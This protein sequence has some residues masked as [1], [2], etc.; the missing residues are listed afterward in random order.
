MSM[1]WEIGMAMGS[2]YDE[3]GYLGIQYDGEGEQ[4]SGVDPFETHAIAGV[5][6]RPMD[7]GVDE[8]G[9]PDP[10]QA[11]QVLVGIEASGKGHI[12]PMEDPRVVALLP[13]AQPGERFFYG[14]TGAF[15]RFHIDGAIS[16]YTTDQG[17]NPAGQ[18]VAM[19]LAPDGW[20]VDAPWGRMTF[21][22]NG[23]YIS[24]AGGPTFDM[25]AMSLPAP[26]DQISSSI[27]MQAKSITL[28]AASV[29]AGPGA[30]TSQPLVGVTALQQVLAA[31]V[32]VIQG[33]STTLTT[34]GT[35]SAGPVAIPGAAAVAPLVQTLQT[36]IATLSAPGN[37]VGLAT[38]VT[39]T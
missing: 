32:G 20:S 6:S 15:I 29:D 1:R 10:K 4:D 18:K 19:R 37:P 17:G 35:S 30:G 38:S 9:N 16:F 5:Y 36:L 33:I 14:D 25:S 31:L 13:A 27:T 34:G 28:D 8:N 11:A 22:G 21:D 39:S 26:L 2:S 23:F 7:P 24:V 3:D 12:W